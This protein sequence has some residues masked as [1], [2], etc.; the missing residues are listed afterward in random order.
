LT[1]IQVLGHFGKVLMRKKLKT[2]RTSMFVT[3][4]V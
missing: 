1:K 2:I 3:K 4:N